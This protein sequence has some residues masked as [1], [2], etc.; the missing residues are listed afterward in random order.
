MRIAGALSGRLGVRMRC[1]PACS[2]VRPPL[3]RVQGVANE[4]HAGLLGSTTPLAAVAGDAAGNDVLPV[5]SAALGDR[6][7]MIEGQIRAWQFP[8]AVL[9]RVLDA[10]VDVGAR[11]RHV[12][13]L[14]LDPDVAQQ[15]NDRGQT[16]AEGGRADLALVRLDDLDFPLAPQRD[17]LLPV[18]DL[19]GLVRGVEEERLLHKAWVI[20]PDGIAGCQR[21]G[22][23]APPGR[24]FKRSWPARAARLQL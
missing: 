23:E 9:T 19:Q 16:E 1:M 18:D 20:V 14:P 21:A 6:H 2:G 11:E 10:R 15:A 3:R 7:H 12:V 17:R 5:F 24:L 8:P 4:M 13:D 22:G